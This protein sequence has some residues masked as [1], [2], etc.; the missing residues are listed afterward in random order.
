MTGGLVG[1]AVGP[2]YDLVTGLGSIDVAKLLAS[3]SVETSPGTT[4][5]VPGP[6]SGLWFNPNE[7][8]WG[9]GFTQRRNIVFATWF[10]YDGSGNPKWYVASSCSMAAGN[11]G[12]SG[13]CSG[14]LFEV[15][16]P[17]FFG[18]AFDP[19]LVHVAAVGSLTV[20]F[21]NANAATMSYT[22][23]GQSRTVA[24]VRQI[25]QSGPTPPPVDFTDLWWNP[26]E[27]GWGLLVSHQ[28]GVMFLAWFVYDSNGKPVWYVASDC[29]VTA[30]GCSGTVFRTTG[31]PFGPSFDPSLVH[32]FA[33]G[34]ITLTFSDPNNGFLTFTVN[35]VS[36]SKSITR[37]LF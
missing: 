18:A 22:V 35:G 34:T 2:G 23:N 25:F 20:N 13:T 37:Q 5:N 19:A 8:G 21:Q 24:I 11:T 26:N 36:G 33:T 1:Y 30:S 32:S 3:W 10:T 29:V 15:G 7:S 31:P 12:A 9:I 16:G 17:T 28:Y 27:S 4:A 14:S 6:L